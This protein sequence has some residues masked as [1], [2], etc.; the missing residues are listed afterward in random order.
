MRDLVLVGGTV[1]SALVNLLLVA[2]FLMSLFLGDLVITL[3]DLILLIVF[4]FIA[5]RLRR[6]VVGGQGPTPAR[7]NRPCH[8]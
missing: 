4:N 7:W 8:D 3:V 6:R 1:V 5:V 2:S